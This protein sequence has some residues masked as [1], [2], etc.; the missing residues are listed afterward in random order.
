[1]KVK[2]VIVYG[3]TFMCNGRASTWPHVVLFTPFAL[4]FPSFPC[5]AGGGSFG[6]LSV[7][8]DR[9]SGMGRG[10]MGQAVGRALGR[11][12]TP[13]PPDARV[14]GIPEVGPRAG[15]HGEVGVEGGLATVRVR[16]MEASGLGKG[17]CYVQVQLTRPQR[18]SREGHAMAEGEHPRQKG[19]THSVRVGRATK[20]RARW[21][22]DGATF[23]M[24]MDDDKQALVVTAKRSKGCGVNAV[25]GHATIDLE[26]LSRR[27]SRSEAD[28]GPPQAHVAWFPLL[29]GRGAKKGGKGVVD[30]RE[31]DAAGPKVGDV[32]LS[33]EVL[34]VRLA[35]VY[36]SI[37]SVTVPSGSGPAYV[38]MVLGTQ[39]DPKNTPVFSLG[40][41]TQPVA[42]VS[43]TLPDMR[44]IVRSL[45]ELIEGAM[46]S[47]V[48]G[49]DGR[50]LGD[51]RVPL[52]Q[53]CAG[54]GAGDR[55]THTSL[56]FVDAS[57]EPRGGHVRIKLHL[58]PTTLGVGPLATVPRL[59]TRLG[60]LRISA[61]TQLDGEEV[62]SA[63][64]EATSF[65]EDF[66]CTVVVPPGVRRLAVR[67]WPFDRHAQAVRVRWGDRLDMAD[68]TA[69][70]PRVTIDIPEGPSAFEV[71]VVAQ[72]GTLGSYIVSCEGIGEDKSALLEA[73][74][75][76]A[77]IELAA[78]EEE[79]EVTSNLFLGSL[80]LGPSGVKL[81]PEFSP[82][83]L[84]YSASVP[85]AVKSLE[86][87]AM[88]S[89]R[90]ETMGI[91]LGDRENW[92]PGDEIRAFP[93]LS[94]TEG[95]NLL[96][97][98]LEDGGRQGIYTIAVR[99]RDASLVRLELS[100]QD[101][102]AVALDP[103]FDPDIY[104]YAA[105][106]SGGDSA[107]YVSLT[108]GPNCMAPPLIRLD[109][110]D[111]GSA[112][113]EEMGNGPM[114][115]MRVSLSPG[116]NIMEILVPLVDGEDGQEDVNVPIVHPAQEEDSDNRSLSGSENEL[117]VPRLIE[118]YEAMFGKLPSKA[119]ESE[120]N[121]SD[122][123]I[124]GPVATYTVHIAMRPS[125][126]SV[127]PE[128][129]SEEDAE[130]PKSP[131][132]GPLLEGMLVSD[133]ELTPAFE[134]RL[135]TYSTQVQH[136]IDMMPI[137]LRPTP[138]SEVSVEME[139]DQGPVR[140]PWS[141]EE[142]SSFRVP[143]RV[144]ETAVKVMVRSTVTGAESSYWI[145][146]SRP[147]ALR[148]D[149]LEITQ[150]DVQQSPFNDVLHALVAM[151]GEC[152]RR[153]L[154]REHGYG[155]EGAPAFTW[156]YPFD[157]DRLHY[158]AAV[159]HEVRSVNIRALAH[160]SLSVSG[161]DQCHLCEGANQIR[162]IVTQK[163]GDG[164]SCVEYL[165]DVVREPDAHSPD[166]KNQ[167]SPALA[168]LSV[169][170]LASVAPESE[171][172]DGGQTRRTGR[173]MA[174]AAEGEFTPRPLTQGMPTAS[175]PKETSATVYEVCA[176][177]INLAD[178]IP[179]VSYA[180]PVGEAD[181]A[182]VTA[183][184]I[185][186][187]ASQVAINGIQDEGLPRG[188]F[189]LAHGPN[190][191]RVEVFTEGYEIPFAYSLCL[192][193]GAVGEIRLSNMD[194]ATHEIAESET[195]GRQ[196]LLFCKWLVNAF[197]RRFK[198]PMDPGRRTLGGILLVISGLG[199]L[200][201]SAD[202]KRSQEPQGSD[203]EPESGAPRQQRRVLRRGGT[204]HDILHCDAVPAEASPVTSRSVQFAMG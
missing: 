83:I 63:L 204:R 47:V 195:T 185:F 179:F 85:H 91:L 193:K 129:E 10:E 26:N 4:S 147:P 184:A 37:E 165:I 79:P 55:V 20:G 78:A 111:V 5:R 191:V 42:E 41:E 32:R 46:M 107:V 133:A 102:S 18:R 119:Q 69:S 151:H 24:A 188:P 80:H 126:V 25:F 93:A 100:A 105:A 136:W 39:S 72:D 123:I 190:I 176:P 75:D 7:Q 122:H 116:A 177:S 162:V 140:S 97:I 66:V 173:G 74:K 197:L 143:V 57:G 164:S 27:P 186:P 145:T 189:R 94:L 202:S 182:I 103:S 28:G 71:E 52:V 142:E 171:R 150:H 49:S 54:S 180:V 82:E 29:P 170:L 201:A 14:S 131:V 125:P 90:V 11:R 141:E 84:H 166:I 192:R 112:L 196:W 101:G 30:V 76:R 31:G 183:E 159:P 172:R 120:A 108:A 38:S 21:E 137:T 138:G 81:V 158:F 59:I 8:I 128:V 181:A 154:E 70:N 124:K 134:S 118:R 163:D 144:G 12:G 73:Q 17:D 132:P 99:R 86:I 139:G 68:I 146:A 95:L 187:D 35:D 61:L 148:L 161:A 96:Q 135:S 169:Q 13:P 9:P 121:L 62:E 149:A 6:R 2:N 43:P 156:P 115:P 23:T 113:L 88:P 92:M 22:A 19:R 67:A 106:V 130:L 175:E 104:E 64:A 60:L 198:E 127:I 58:R 114:K 117:T 98:V 155:E 153:D 34:H 167:R 178:P 109:D 45:D 16:V 199:F 203:I 194:F 77:T 157:P 48:S 40:D 3:S 152:K 50:S 33:I 110:V 15:L 174:P 89:F 168:Q 200:T 53:L 65:E 44:L 51:C 1:M 87:H 36:A 56:A 160:P